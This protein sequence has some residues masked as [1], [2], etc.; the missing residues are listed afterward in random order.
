MAEVDLWQ[1]RNRAIDFIAGPLAEVDHLIRAEFSLLDLVITEFNR[2]SGSDV[3]PRVCGLTTAKARA[4]LQATYSLI[5]DGLAQEAG[6]LLRPTL[7]AYELLV[8]FTLDRSRAEEA[9]A[10][11]LPNAGTVAK[12]IGGSFKGLREHLSTNASHL[13]FTPYSMR[14]L[15]DY[16]TATLRTTQPF[17]P[18]LL[19]ENME[20]L[21]AILAL[22][23]AQCVPAL[24]SAGSAESAT[25]AD[26]GDRLW[27]EGRA[28]M[29]LRSTP[30]QS[31]TKS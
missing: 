31:A 23:A 11:T 24:E 18:V 4:L 28:L 8:Y 13:A 20:A 3:F 5:L 27:S 22:F 16:R 29:A 26:E 9:V 21:F 25:L 6:A 17:L 10:G 19:R 14:H 12:R 7:E 30:P 15:V 2:P 1:T